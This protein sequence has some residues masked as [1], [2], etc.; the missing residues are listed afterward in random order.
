MS[1]DVNESHLLIYHTYEGELPAKQYTRLSNRYPDRYLLLEVLSEG[2]LYR[3]RLRDGNISLADSKIQPF[4]DFLSSE[5]ES[6]KE[7][8]SED[9]AKD[10][11][12]ISES[13]ALTQNSKV[14]QQKQTRI[15]REEAA[16]K[17]TPNKDKFSIQLPDDLVLLLLEYAKIF[18]RESLTNNEL[19]YFS[20]AYK[21]GDF[22]LVEF[23]VQIRATSFT[24][25]IP[26]FAMGYIRLGSLISA[27]LNDIVTI[28]RQDIRIAMRFVDYCFVPQELICHALLQG[29]DKYVRNKRVKGNIDINFDAPITRSLIALKF[30][31]CSIDLTSYCN[32]TR[33]YAERVGSPNKDF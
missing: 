15:S 5:S 12:S 23:L 28:N 4:L 11:T 1:I 20:H 24:A 6:E 29:Y 31:A 13:F 21:F 22:A 26:L 8:P 14:S 32:A 27:F 30:D 33:A 2:S 7:E 17:F 10:T 9:S 16:N 18:E 25:Q 19:A 3:F